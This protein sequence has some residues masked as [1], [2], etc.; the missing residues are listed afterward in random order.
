MNLAIIILNY[1]TPEL[2]IDCLASLE[3]EI[4]LSTC[5]VVVDN[6]SGDGSAELIAEAIE[7]RGWSTW[8][9]LLRSP[10]NGGFAAGN[11][12]GIRS[13]R[14]NGYLLLNSDTLVRP[15]AIASLRQAMRSRPDAGVIGAGLLDADGR[16]DQ[17][18][19]RV[20]A[21]VTELIRAA[22]VGV[23]ARAFERFD[24]IMPRGD[25]PLEPGWLAFA[26]VVIRREVIEQVGLLDE[27]YFM[28][29]ED[30]DYCRRAREAGW[31]VL[32]WPAA[33][34]VHLK[35][36]SS[37]VTADAAA[38]RRAPRYYYEA[39]ARYFARFYGRPGLWLANGLWCLGRCISWPRELC[40]NAK[41]RLR[42]HEAFDIWTSALR[43]LR[44]HA[45]AAASRS[46]RRRVYPPAIPPS[47]D[48]PLPEGRTNT[49][50]PGIGLLSLLAE[51]FRTHDRSAAS[52]G[53]WAVAVHRFGNA[54]MDVRPR[55]LRVPLTVAYRLASTGVNWLWGIDLSYTVK[56]GR[57][58]R[59]WH[60]G[61]IV[62][63]A[64]AIGDD[65][66]L[67]H[68]TTLGVAHREKTGEKPIIGNRV[69]I[70]VGS[71]VLGAVTVGDDCVIGANS[72]VVRDLP[73]RC[74]AAGIPARVVRAR[75]TNGHRRN[76]DVVTR[77]PRRSE[78]RLQVWK[79][80]GER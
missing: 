30:I 75:R 12:L 4:D 74:I 53:F 13:L 36:S 77:E 16:P 26:A 3:R 72:V 70:G 44:A 67:R 21:P 23:L 56:L 60:H 78:T 76:Q 52:P 80:N 29:F 31:K 49:N 51:D 17:S 14:A 42:E 71:C 20:P 33:E 62:L 59:I 6:A 5:A 8:A 18:F 24:P 43:P 11:N 41:P 69:D 39:R 40:G 79:A 48:A 58:V 55:L 34:I 7:Q 54:R 50:P 47:H 10:V 46:V 63:S 19:F 37:L 32:Y 57:R 66:H 38:R 27:G 15:G 73:A 22:G 28:Y 64:R 68:N 45:G 2:T 65:V 35:G 1:R 25:G 61:G 9:T